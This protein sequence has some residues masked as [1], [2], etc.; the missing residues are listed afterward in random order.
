MSMQ[1]TV[2]GLK[3]T[4]C[5]SK[6][7]IVDPMQP[8]IT[9]LKHVACTAVCTTDCSR[10]VSTQY[11][12]CVIPT[13]GTT[14]RSSPIQEE[15]HYSSKLGSKK[16]LGVRFCKQAK[17]L[18]YTRKCRAINQSS[19]IPTHSF[20][21]TATLELEMNGLKFPLTQTQE[22]KSKLDSR[23]TSGVVTKTTAIAAITTN[24]NDA[25]PM[26]GILAY[27]STEANTEQSMECA[28]KSAKSF[29]TTMSPIMMD[30]TAAF[31]GMAC[32]ANVSDVQPHPSNSPTDKLWRFGR[33]LVLDDIMDVGN[34]H[35]QSKRFH[36]SKPECSP[37]STYAT[38]SRSNERL[39][40]HSCKRARVVP[41]T[42]KCKVCNH[43]SKDST[44][45]LS[46]PSQKASQKLE[47]DAF[48]LPQTQKLQELK[49]AEQK[50]L[51]IPMCTKDAEGFKVPT[52]PPVRIA[53][54]KG[55]KRST[56]SALSQATEQS[57]TI[58]KVYISE[59][60]SAAQKASSNNVISLNQH[61][62]A[63]SVEDLISAFTTTLKMPYSELPCNQQK[64]EQTCSPSTRQLQSSLVP[65]VFLPHLGEVELVACNEGN[66][67]HTTVENSCENKLPVDGSMLTPLPPMISDHALD[68]IE[69]E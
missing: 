30:K 7:D 52:C 57:G 6:V 54:Q 59:P 31:G 43:S 19:K 35:C 55:A 3:K 48:I 32:T 10:A 8:S 50:K 14:G 28:M 40:G 13:L 67:Y 24:T 11:S 56:Q 45:N 23:G 37:L 33:R 16:Y 18:P 27:Q 62:T 66:T 68:N 12:S 39:G 15:P 29:S 5:N 9:T 42:R 21:R 1:S 58:P 38:K 49:D 69:S 36:Q 61:Q 41:Y 51:I 22:H 20:P 34:N 4:C 65:A 17:I 25:V 26:E 2:N 60:H 46:P 64:K 63:C 53:C 47:T 44:C